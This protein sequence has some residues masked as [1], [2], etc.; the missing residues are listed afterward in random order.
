MR[1][2]NTWVGLLGIA[3]ATTL[4]CGGSQ[5]TSNTAAKPESPSATPAGQKVDSATA[6][7]V[8][9]VVMVDGAVPKNESIKMNADPVCLKE[10]TTPQSQETY[11]VSDDGKNLGNVFVYV[12]D[13]LGN[14]VF[15]TPT[16]PATI[17]QKN[18][19]Y[20]PHVFGMMINQPLEIINSDPTLHNIHAMPKGNSEF[21][22]GQPIQGMK[23]THTFDKPEVMV[24]FKCDVHGWM[25]AYVGVMS[26]PYFAVTEKDGKFDLPNLPPGTYTIEAWH[27][28]LG[29]QTASVTIGPKESKDITFTFK[30]AGPT[31]T[32]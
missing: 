23:M 16:K 6:G 9:G 30:A 31:A 10:N 14:Y 7:D 17:D 19:R 2:R 26:H 18:C 12:K 8:K 24:P 22:N 1:L 25:N 11:M 21:N 29:T 5:E 32:N 15:D 27:E 4:A 28:K 3:L 20:H 13:G